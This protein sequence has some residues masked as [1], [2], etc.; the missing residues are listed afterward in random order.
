MMTMAATACPACGAP[1]GSNAACLSCREA[2]AGEVLRAAQD[3]TPG[4]VADAERRAG[5]YVASPPWWAR[6]A[7]T[8]LMGR[9]RL[10]WMLL[11]D[12]TQGRYR[13]PWRAVAAVAA[14]ALYVVSPI[15]LIP[16]FLGPLG[17]TDDAMA[18]ALVWRLLKGELVRYCAWKGLSAEHFGL[19]PK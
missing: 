15:D 18:V 16:D 3:V 7:P 19:G 4:R 9:L 11:Q 12:F 10:L 2:A 17:F 1:S 8:G 5:A 6:K 14:A 13:L